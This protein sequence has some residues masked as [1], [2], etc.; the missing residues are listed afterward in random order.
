MTALLSQTFYL[1]AN[2]KVQLVRFALCLALGLAAGV[3]ALLYLRK[4]RPAERALTDFFAT[5]CIG[6]LFAVCLEF[7]LDGK[8]ELYGLAAFVLGVIPIPA[9]TRRVLSKRTKAEDAQKKS[10]DNIPEDKK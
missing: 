1:G 3:I 10:D 9:V 8:F 2:A 4:A 6:A 7:V 5:V